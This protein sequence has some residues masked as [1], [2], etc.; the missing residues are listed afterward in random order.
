MA[1]TTM[2]TTSSCATGCSGVFSWFATSACSRA[3]ECGTTSGRRAPPMRPSS[4]NSAW[5]F[6]SYDGLARLPRGRMIFAL[7][8]TMR[9]L[10]LAGETPEE[11]LLSR[12]RAGDTHAL[13]EVY[14]QHHEAVRA[15]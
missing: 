8:S 13:G 4:P 11:T 12:L 15:F 3:A 14:D 6:K 5:G 1:P 10:S 2:N 9:A 7:Y